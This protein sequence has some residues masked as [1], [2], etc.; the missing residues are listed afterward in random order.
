MTGDCVLQYTK[1]FLFNCVTVWECLAMAMLYHQTGRNQQWKIVLCR[2]LGFLAS[3]FVRQI[4][5]CQFGFSTYGRKTLHYPYLIVGPRK[6]WCSCWNFVAILCTSWDIR[7]QCSEAAIFWFSTSGCFLTSAYHQH[8][9]KGMSLA[10]NVG[11]V[12]KNL[13][14]PSVELKLYYML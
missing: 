7:N 5:G 10:E 13:F 1:W 11:V 9:T 14:P 12:V 8:I 4:R 3:G 2:Y 6:H